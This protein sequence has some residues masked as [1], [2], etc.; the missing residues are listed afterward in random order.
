M[1]YLDQIEIPTELKSE[2]MLVI[3]HVLLKQQDMEF[4]AAS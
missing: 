4:N 1:L 3:I 2:W